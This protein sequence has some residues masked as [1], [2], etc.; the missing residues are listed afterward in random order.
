MCTGNKGIL[1]TIALP[2]CLVPCWGHK[3]LGVDLSS[4]EVY[5]KNQSTISSRRLVEAALDIW[6][7]LACFQLGLPVIVFVQLLA[8]S[9]TSPCNLSKLVGFLF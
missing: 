9:E 7:R 6:P 4:V 3:A 1:A 8:R 5:V 2:T